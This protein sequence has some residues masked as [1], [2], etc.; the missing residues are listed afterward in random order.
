MSHSKALVIAAKDRIAGRLGP[1]LEAKDRLLAR[2][3]LEMLAAEPGEAVDEILGAGQ[4]VEVFRHL[5]AV[6][7][8]E[9]A[10]DRVFRGK[11]AIE[12][13]GAHLRLGGDVLHGGAVEA[14][15]HE[16]ALG[17]VEDAGATLGLGFV[18][19][20]PVGLKGGHGGIQKV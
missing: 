11:V 18:V 16:A 12:V 1:D 6:A 9:A 19:K 3:L 13:A 15:A 14:R 17:C 2:L 5:G 20:R 7:L 10:R 8:G 4:R